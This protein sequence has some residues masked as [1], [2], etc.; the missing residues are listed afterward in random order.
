[1]KVGDVRALVHKAL[2]QWPSTL[3]SKGTRSSF[4]LNGTVDGVKYTI[5]ISN[6]R[7]VQF[8]PRP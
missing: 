1:M 2:K 3:K 7:V 5:K 8:F 6:G 4:T